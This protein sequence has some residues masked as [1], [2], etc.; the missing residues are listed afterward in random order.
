MQQ[1]FWRRWRRW[2]GFLAALFLML[3]SVMA[4]LVTIS[5]FFGEAEAL[6]EAARDLISPLRTTSSPEGTSGIALLQAVASGRWFAPEG[7][8]LISD[9]AATKVAVA[10]DGYPWVLNAKLEIYKRAK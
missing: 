10:P 2:V 1:A 4:V 3:A 5:E 7:W 8:Y 6:R 9:T